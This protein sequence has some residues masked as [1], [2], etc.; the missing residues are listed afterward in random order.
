[1]KFQDDEQQSVRN[2]ADETKEFSPMTVQKNQVSQTTFSYPKK[3]VETETKNSAVTPAMQKPEH[4]GTARKSPNSSCM[5]LPEDT[6]CDSSSPLSSSSFFIRKDEHV[7]PEEQT[8]FVSRSLQE[9][10]MKELSPPLKKM[11]KDY[12]NSEDETRNN[13][14]IRKV[15][16]KQLLYLV[17][18]RKRVKSCNDD[19]NTRNDN[20][21]FEVQL[22][23]RPITRTVIKDGRSE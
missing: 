17:S 5:V 19:D 12:D 8:E 15:I 14:E 22:K 10:A 3:S 20:K 2:D 11:E 9:S 18:A 13:N 16:L 6:E 21:I 4:E 7:A 1:M 23:A